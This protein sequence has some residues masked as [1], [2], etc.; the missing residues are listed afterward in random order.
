MK[1]SI[2]TLVFLIWVNVSMAQRRG[3]DFISVS[4]FGETIAHY[5]GSVS[6]D[7]LFGQR[8]EGALTGDFLYVSVKCNFY[9]HPRNHY[10]FMLHPE[11]GYRRISREGFFLEAAIGPGIIQTFLDGKVYIPDAEDNLQKK[12]L[13]GQTS[14]MS[15]LAIGI[16]GALSR[17]NEAYWKIRPNLIIQREFIRYSYPRF[18]MEAGIVYRVNRDNNE[19]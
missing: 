18:A 6:A 16:G 5:G 13:Q 17:K 1:T 4:Y 8:A 12:R 7:Y 9:R 15:L 3:P 19:R 14:A 11:V 2:V 10:G